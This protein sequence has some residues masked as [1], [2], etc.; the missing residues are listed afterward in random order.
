MTI[1]MIYLNGTYMAEGETEHE[2]WKNARAEAEIAN[3][4]DGWEDEAEI[5]VKHQ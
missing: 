4:A 1:Y 2:A 3:L 5:R